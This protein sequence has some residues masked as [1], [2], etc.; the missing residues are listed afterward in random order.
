[1]VCVFLYSLP[2]M[3]SQ[4]LPW[5]QLEEEAVGGLREGKEKTERYQKELSSDTMR[6]GK[7]SLVSLI[8]DRDTYIA[9]TVYK[10]VISFYITGTHSKQNQNI[11]DIFFQKDFTYLNSLRIMEILEVQRG[12]WINNV[13]VNSVVVYVH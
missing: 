1:M 7:V 11:L 3:L 13:V 6:V 12:L 2:Q 9:Q 5:R 4:C 8:I 10:L